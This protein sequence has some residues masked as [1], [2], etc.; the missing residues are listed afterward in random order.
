M[1]V[2]IFLD[3]PRFWK[4]LLF[5]DSLLEREKMDLLEL[6]D[7]YY[8]RVRK[9]IVT[10]VKDEWAADDLIQETFVRVRNN[11][12]T[13]RDSSKISSWIFRISYNLCQDHFR[14]LK[15]LPVNENTTNVQEND[16]K[17]TLVQKEME[18]SQMGKCVQDQVDLLPE[19]LK[20]VI[21]LFDTMDL[22]HQEIAD[23]LGITVENVKI[24]L[25]RARKKLKSLL[26][27]ECHFERD[28]RNVLICE[29]TRRLY[30][31]K[32]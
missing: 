17:E 19:S 7:Q 12:D 25:H 26:E 9:F 30:G 4:K 29:P 10:L 11:Q 21:V 15:K 28:E 2:V 27:K 13:L 31:Q 6:Y 1:P 5:L 24:R 32:S 16:F 18:Q 23:I 8:A 20:S 22:S 3:I 14:K